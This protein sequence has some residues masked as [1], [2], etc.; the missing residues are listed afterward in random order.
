MRR[1]VSE[2]RVQSSI[3]TKEVVEAV[4]VDP[5]KAAEDAEDAEAVA[6]KDVGVATTATRKS[7]V[8]VISSYNT[9]PRR[10]TVR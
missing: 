10:N 2:E 3:E 4:E 8:T 7:N 6:L 1:V 9:I 5:I